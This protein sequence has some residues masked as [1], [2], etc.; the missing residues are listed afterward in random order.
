MGASGAVIVQHI[1]GKLT[2]GFVRE[3]EPQQRVLSVLPDATAPKGVDVPMSS[4][5]AIHFVRSLEHGLE[6]RFGDPS[7]EPAGDLSTVE[8]VDLST[9]RARKEQLVQGRGYWLRPEHGDANATRIFVPAQGVQSI[10]PVGGKPAQ[11][12]PAAAPAKPGSGFAV[13]FLGGKAEDEAHANVSATHAAPG[14][15]AAGGATPWAATSGPAAPQRPAP[16]NVSAGAPWLAQAAAPPA[17]SAWTPPVTSSSPLVSTPDPL[18]SL[19]LPAVEPAPAEPPA[20][21]RT[22]DPSGNPAWGAPA[23]AGAPAQQPQPAPQSNPPAQPA[24]SN[25][26]AGSPPWNPQTP[27]AGPAWSPPVAEPAVAWQT[28]AG[29]QQPTQGWSAPAPQ[30]APSA[31]PRGPQ[32]APQPSS[33]PAWVAP[34]Q[35]S[36]APAWSAPPAGAGPQPAP[37]WGPAGGPPP[38]AAWVS[39]PAPQPAWS[40]AQPPPNAPPQNL[41]GS[42]GAWSAQA[43][44]AQPWSAQTGQLAPQGPPGPAWGAQPQPWG[45]RTPNPAWGPAGPAWP[46]SSGPRPQTQQ[47]AW[48]QQPGA[49]AWPQP[50]QPS[51]PTGTQPPGPGWPQGQAPAWPAQPGWP[52]GRS[53][54]WPPPQTRAPVPPV[55]APPGGAPQAPSAPPLHHDAGHSAP[56]P[57]L[58]AAPHTRPAP[59]RSSSPALVSADTPFASAPLIGPTPE[60]ELPDEILTP[61]VVSIPALP[62]PSLPIERVASASDPATKGRDLDLSSDLVLG[63]GEPIEHPF[64]PPLA[65]D[66]DMISPTDS[67]PPPRISSS[68][69]VPVVP[70]ASSPHVEPMDNSPWAE[71]TPPVPP[72]KPPPPDPPRAKPATPAQAWARPQTPSAADVWSKPA[73]KDAWSLPAD[74]WIASGAQSREVPRVEPRRSDPSTHGP[75][76]P[77]PRRGSE[78]GSRPIT[79]DLPQKPKTADVPRTRT[80]ER[81]ASSAR[82]VEASRGRVDELPSRIPSAVTEPMR[83]HPR[84]EPPR[85]PAPPKVEEKKRDLDDEL[86]AYLED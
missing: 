31:P 76:D 65:P 73:P 43:P 62:I 71:V 60:L 55:G 1:G 85:P 58:E 72:P 53:A 33:A 12:A 48:P 11:R 56:S 38:A 17:S 21:Q 4:I 32:S 80:A 51:W 5:K 41:G 28:A 10:K 61:P 20:A 42:P 66:D 50:A 22:P 45:A 46:Q 86:R 54:P 30:Q 84:P 13:S 36:S 69:K 67:T 7:A 49:P 83:P 74:Q 59:P 79:G 6:D 78:P 25:P 3:F 75:S 27:Q 63:A 52:Q 70:L 81:Q 14:A 2:L 9:M 23:W 57:T 34:S 40:A 77:L 35:P 64:V 15:A 29:P 68:P 19:E 24:W 47:P 37:A 26:S 39:S 16:A 18:S 82:P 44:P 8:F